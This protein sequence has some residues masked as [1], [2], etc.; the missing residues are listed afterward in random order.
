M[1][2]NGVAVVT[3][4]EAFARD[5][6]A[7]QAGTPP[8]ILM[9][10]AGVAAATV[11][12]RRF[13][14]LVSAGVEIR[15]G[16][17]NNGG[18]GWVVA[19]ELARLGIPV[20][21]IEALPPG[22]PDAIAAKEAAE[23]RSFGKVSGQT[24]IV[25]DALLGTGSVGTPRGEIR[26]AVQSIND[27]RMRGAE[28][29]ALDLP[30][31]LEASTGTVSEAVH[32]TLTLSFGTL[33]RGHLIARDVCGAIDV[34]DIGLRD[35]GKPASEDCVLAD[36]RWVA[37]NIPRIQADAHKG[38][39]KRL[40]I[41]A[42]DRGMAGAAILAG[43]AALRSG[44]GLL[45]LIVASEN[46]DAVHV[47][48]PAALVSTYEELLAQPAETLRSA[49]AIVIGPG[50]TPNHAQAILDVLPGSKAPVVLDAGSLT[51]LAG[52]ITAMK[53]L[54]RNRELVLTPHPAEMGR[55][56][57][58]SSADVLANRF[59]VGATVA[60]ELGVTVLLKGTPTIVSGAGGRRVVSATGTPALATGGSGDLLSGIIGTLLAQTEKGFESAICGAWVHGRAAELCGTSRGV[61]LD[62]ILYAMPA[63][64]N[65]PTSQRMPP[66]LTSLPAIQ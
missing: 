2:T 55:L 3:A 36:D 24:A 66:V 49:D 43:K 53:S 56:V 65:I 14:E 31:G 57:G 27:A 40:A 52:D 23:A 5:L 15:T 61:T 51:S 35:F 26:S 16:P 33:K 59:E 41:I 39:R 50:L 58:Q 60:R 48:I 13:R 1:D 47:A 30:T 32:A 34:L 4:P 11:I 62:D 6:R 12:A 28:V 64:W 44:I 25:V 17:G 63:A 7:I 46:R 10:N 19:G 38:T 18:D 22:K 45:H 42:G 21:V 29:V 8:R 54:V 9:Q 37:A 20:Q